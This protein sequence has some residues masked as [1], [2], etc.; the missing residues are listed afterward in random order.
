ML[1]IGI[2]IAFFHLFVWQIAAIL[3]FADPPPHTLST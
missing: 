3:T 1:N 2:N